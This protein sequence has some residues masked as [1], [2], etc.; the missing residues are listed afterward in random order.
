MPAVL[1]SILFT[2]GGALECYHNS[3]WKAKCSNLIA[4][5]SVINT[6]G[7]LFFLVAATSGFLGVKNSKWW[8][9]FTYIVGSGF[10]LIG[11]LMVLH[12]WNGESYG[13]AFIHEI[14]MKRTE[15][16]EQQKVLLKE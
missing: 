8:V 3:I 6:L 15:D 2:S 16:T 10:F 7:A 9:D 5:I 13:L 14:N 11:S 1:G 12:M 4:W